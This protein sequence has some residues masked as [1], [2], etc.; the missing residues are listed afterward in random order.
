MHTLTVRAMPREGFDRFFRGGHMWPTAGRTVQV[1]D[2]L[3]AVLMEED[4]LAKDPARGEPEAEV[5]DLI[6]NRAHYDHAWNASRSTRL[7][8]AEEERQLN[9]RE[10]ELKID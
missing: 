9:I 6:D 10:S 3:Y 1:T 8:L 2:A 4:K 5:L 7:T